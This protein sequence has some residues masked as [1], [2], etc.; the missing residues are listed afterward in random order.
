MVQLKDVVSFN[1]IGQKVQETLHSQTGQT[2]RDT[3]RAELIYRV[4]IRF[5]FF[6]LSVRT[7]TPSLEDYEQVDIVHTSFAG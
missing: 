3:G 4:N 5:I 7:A 2:D 1:E 6:F